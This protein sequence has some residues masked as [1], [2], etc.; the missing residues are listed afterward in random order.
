MVK[1][2]FRLRD[3]INGFLQFWLT[4]AK[5]VLFSKWNV[6]LPTPKGNRIAYLANGP[7]LPS[8]IEKM[9][10][11][12]GLPENIMVSNLFSR[13]DLF[14]QLQPNY[15]L[16][17]DPALSSH[18][19]VMGNEAWKDFYVQLYAKTTWELVFFVPFK[20]RKQVQWIIKDLK[21]S[22]DNI[23]IC[24]YNSVNF[25]GNYWFN[26]PLFNANL[27]IPRPTT[28]AVPALMLCLGMGFKEIELG[29][30]DLNMHQDLVLSNDNVVN[31]R[32]VHFYTKQE[33]IAP[34]Y[35]TP[36][37]KEIFTMSEIFRHFHFVF[38]SFEIVAKFAR[39]KGA[40]VRN[41]SKD[42]F[43]DQFERMTD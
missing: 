16:I 43:L 26:F 39:K 14:D 30:L 28:V 19:S 21:L 12:G 8:C 35:K 5:L 7:S 10:Q 4:L 41:F 20:Y 25:N 1:L 34:Y 23:S 6:K 2:L 31:M 9:K 22:N 3:G 17:C 38:F 40:K 24:Y 18:F 33:S 29:G 15:Y 13:T 11:Q 27:G 32:L 42:S 37:K 36:E